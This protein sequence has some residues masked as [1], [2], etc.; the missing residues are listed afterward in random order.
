MKYPEEKVQKIIKLHSEGKSPFEISKLFNTYNTTIRRILLR[1]N[2]KL[3]DQSEAQVSV[4]KNPFEN[5]ETDEK[6]A[7][8]LGYL[9]S[10]G[11]VSIGK[12]GYR[13][14]LNTNK[15]PEHLQKYADYIRK[16]LRKYWNKTYKTWEYSVV[17]YNKRIVNW[18]IELGITPNKSLTFEFKGKLNYNIVRGIFDG[19]G[20]IHSDG[21]ISIVTGSPKFKD[22]IL[23]YYKENGFFCTA[24]EDKRGNKCW[25]IYI[26]GQEKFYNFM[27][28]NADIKMQRK[29]QLLGQLIS[30]N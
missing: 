27:Y 3:K 13:V 18:L 25:N 14:I 24:Y 29:E 21:R 9:I 19:D 5:Y 15:D 23:Y 6:A 30:N 10:D 20:C 28:L 16:P 12:A 2:I 8:W 7:Y 4:I 1:N 22:Q 17:F 11:C 26:T